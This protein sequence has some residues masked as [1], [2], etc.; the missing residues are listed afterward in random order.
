MAKEN[1]TRYQQSVI[2]R[3][4]ENRDN[5][6]LQH[7]QEQVTELYLAEGKK[8]L[9]VWESLAKNLEKLGVPADQVAQL[10]TA[11][12]PEQVAQLLQDKF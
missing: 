11:D 5:L 4:Y 2:K 3:F 9:K 10:R 8:R 7:A 12:K 1:Y 6:A